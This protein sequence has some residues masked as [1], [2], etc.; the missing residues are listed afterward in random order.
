MC[1]RDRYEADYAGWMLFLSQVT[2][3]LGSLI[4]PVFAGKKKDQRSLVWFLIILELIGL[5]GLILPKFGL[6]PLWVSLI[7]F[8]LGGCFG[9]SLL[10]IVLRSKDADATTELSGMAQSIGYFVAGTGPILFGSIFDFTGSWNYAFILL[11]I[12]VFLKLITG[13]GASKPV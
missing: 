2:G 12:A 7:G 1:I 5:I 10:L 13:L 4:I 6:V 9:L 3:I 8:V 11:F